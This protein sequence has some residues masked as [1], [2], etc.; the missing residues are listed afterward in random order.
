M[1]IPSNSLANGPNL[2]IESF[3]G[4]HFSDRRLGVLSR[5]NSAITES[6]RPPGAVFLAFLNGFVH[7]GPVDII[8]D[9]FSSGG[10]KSEIL[11]RLARCHVATSSAGRDF[12]AGKEMLRQVNQDARE[13]LRGLTP[14]A[15]Q[16]MLKGT[17]LG[18]RDLIVL[19]FPDY[20]LRMPLESDCFGD[21]DGAL[22]EAES[23]QL[24]S[25][26]DDTDRTLIGN[27]AREQKRSHAGYYDSGVLR[28]WSSFLE[29]C[30]GQTPIESLGGQDRLHELALA[31]R[32]VARGAATQA[33]HAGIPLASALRISAKLF[34]AANRPKAS[35]LVWR[36]I[37]KHHHEAGETSMRIDALNRAGAKLSLAADLFLTQTQEEK[38]RD[39][40]EMAF[41]VYRESGNLAQ[42]SRTGMT[43]YERHIRSNL[44]SEARAVAAVV[45]NTE[46]RM[47]D[48]AQARQWSEQAMQ[49]PRASRG[50]ESSASSD[51]SESLQVSR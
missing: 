22:S 49:G 50:A 1:T 14:A 6:A 35:G 2:P 34:D 47:G 10:K 9:C 37:A 26:R 28:A 7:M 21:G 39:C 4:H 48:I 45:A 27:F 38:A 40:L 3:P 17:R 5:F 18:A 41:D 19:T 29:R 42:T 33:N 32:A 8:R 36:D 25:N 16:T 20:E 15:R 12:L 31:Y 24:M 43:L 30:R 23:R 13:L 44:P 11:S 46:R 51:A